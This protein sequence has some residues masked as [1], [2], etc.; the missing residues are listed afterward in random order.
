MLVAHAARVRLTKTHASHVRYAE[1]P[2]A[3]LYVER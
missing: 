1:D 2:P 3:T